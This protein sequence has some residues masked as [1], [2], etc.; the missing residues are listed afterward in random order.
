MILRLMTLILYYSVNWYIILIDLNPMRVTDFQ[1]KKPFF[2]RGRT[3]VKLKF[4]KCK[5]GLSPNRYVGEE[6]SLLFMSDLRG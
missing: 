6:A 5:K 4:D 3:L 1:K 2:F